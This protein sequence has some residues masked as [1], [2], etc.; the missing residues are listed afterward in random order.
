MAL[1]QIEPSWKKSL[2]ERTYYTKDGKTIVVE[3]G[4]RW[5]SFT[6]ETDDDTP[7]ILE[8]GV[9]LWNCDY[10]VEMQETFD[11]CWEDHEFYGF[12]EEE[13]AAMVEWLEENSA[14]ELEENGWSQSDNEMIMDCEPS[15]E[16]LE[17]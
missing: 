13:E 5:G 3:T 10:E 12:T 4:W 1:W 8:H 7:P 16:R 17:E 6:I 15:I 11:G 14:W 2:L 9:D